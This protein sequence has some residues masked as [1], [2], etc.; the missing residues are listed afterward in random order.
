MRR[1]VKVTPA[2]ASGPLALTPVDPWLRVVAR[3]HDRRKGGVKIAVEVSGAGEL[4]LSC[5]GVKTS[6]RQVSGAGTVKLQL[7]PTGELARELRRSIVTAEVTITF[8]PSGGKAIIK[9]LRVRLVRGARRRANAS[10]SP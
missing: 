2:S 9:Q 6:P 10:P 8:T 1:A 3:E 5:R 4:V 7:S